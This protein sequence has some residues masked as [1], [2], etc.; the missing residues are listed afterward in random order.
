[1][2]ATTCS[3]GKVAITVVVGVAAV[4][5]A[6]AL[7]G[8]GGGSWG[9]SRTG[10][11]GGVDGLVGGDGFLDGVGDGTGSWGRGSRGSSGDA[12]TARGGS[13]GRRGR[14][15]SGGR[16]GCWG[17][18]AG[19]GGRDD[20][21]WGGVSGGEDVV[22]GTVGESPSE[23][24]RWLFLV[25]TRESNLTEGVGPIEWLFGSLL[26]VG[27][28]VLAVTW[29]L[30][31]GK[32]GSL[33]T[34]SDSAVKA[35]HVHLVG[36]VLSLPEPSTDTLSIWTFGHTSWDIELGAEGLDTRVVDS[37]NDEILRL[38]L[39]SIALVSNGKTASEHLVVVEWVTSVHGLD[40][41]WAR[42]VSW[43]GGSHRG[44]L[45]AAGKLGD[46][47]STSLELE[48]LDTGLWRLVEVTVEPPVVEAHS[49]QWSD[50][51]IAIRFSTAIAR[52]MPETNVSVNGCWKRGGGER[53]E[54]KELHS[55]EE[56]K[57]I[58]GLDV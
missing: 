23:V 29:D 12:S 51:I 48:G 1:M 31:G 15:A 57:L 19:T 33:G 26:T 56:S 30:G 42:V 44:K 50:W 10:N 7:P 46:S 8:A 34:S 22:L 37:E 47:L 32:S 45:S 55:V 6:V 53:E 9:S 24:V 16:E 49:G 36:R 35:S 38:D 43:V 39:G 58:K 25:N 28:I 54:S 20:W 41:N 5:F 13:A 18:R 2:S 3:A 11:D 21:S 17:G 14:S 52:L 40:V 27:L 4:T